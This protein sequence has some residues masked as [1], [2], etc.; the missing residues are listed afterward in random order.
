MVEV[1]KIIKDL[2]ARKAEIIKPVILEN[3]LEGKIKNIYC[4][5]RYG[6]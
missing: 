6:L 4:A 2:Q 5:L 3:N 1:M